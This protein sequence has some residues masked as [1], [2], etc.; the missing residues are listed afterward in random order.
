VTL[1]A[2]G[3]GGVDTLEQI[4]DVEVDAAPISIFTPS[5]VL[6]FIADPLVTFAN[7]SE[8]ADGYY[9][10]FGDGEV[11]TDVNPWH[12]Y[13]STGDFYVSLIAINGDCPN[14]TSTALIEVRDVD[15]INEL[16][17]ME[18]D[19]YPNPATDFIQLISA[20]PLDSPFN[21]LIYD[22]QGKLVQQSNQSKV[23]GNQQIYIG[24]LAKGLYY[25]KIGQ[26][27]AIHLT[28]FVVQ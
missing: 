20:F 6:L 23:T 11:S 5:N 13:A 4:V 14:D 9:W 28:K 24:D 19:V 1:V 21:Y 10:E 8:N 2:T 25:L 7:S 15:G 12:A 17:G 3:P 16:S 27:A 26:A 22:A 18:L